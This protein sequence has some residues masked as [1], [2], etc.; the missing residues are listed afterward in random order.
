MTVSRTSTQCANWR[1]AQVARS[2]TPEKLAVYHR[3]M[4]RALVAQVRNKV[5]SLLAPVR[6]ALLKMATSQNPNL[7]EASKSSR[8]V[9]YAM[10]AMLHCSVSMASFPKALLDL[11][12]R[13]DAQARCTDDKSVD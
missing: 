13:D 9:P 10:G 11:G 4:S 1:L 5:R 6:R 12:G 3:Q 7:I 8:L 2:V